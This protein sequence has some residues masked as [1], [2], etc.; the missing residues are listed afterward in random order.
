MHEVQV[1]VEEA[2]RQLVATDATQLVGLARK[3]LDTQAVHTLL[4]E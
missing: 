2:V 3:K 1:V 4:A